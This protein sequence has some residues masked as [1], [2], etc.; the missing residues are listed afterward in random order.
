MF[1]KSTITFILLATLALTSCKKQN[2]TGCFKVKYVDGMCYTNV[3]QI[4][5]PGFKHLG[6]PNWTRQQD[7]KVF[8]NVFVLQN[9]CEDLG[10]TYNA[11]DSTYTVRLL[12]NNETINTNCITCYAAYNNPPLKSLALKSTNCDE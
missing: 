11:T 4:I 8:N 10:S 6:Q 9:H 3:F 7:G 1:M 12:N 5:T 2:P